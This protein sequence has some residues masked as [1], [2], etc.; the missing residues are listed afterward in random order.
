MQ[1][2][3]STHH[4]ERS[5][6]PSN[7]FDKSLFNNGSFLTPDVRQKVIAIGGGKG[8]VGKSL[9]SANLSI[10]LSLM[11]YKVV[12]VD[13]D[14]GGANLHTCLG[15]PI[16]EH[17]LSDFFLQKTQN[18]SDL[19]VDTNFKN[20]KLISGAQDHIHMANLKS[21]N[22]NKLIKAVQEIDADYVLL[23]LGAGTTFNTLDFFIK[24]D[25][26]VLVVLPEPTSIE[27]TYRF[28]KSIFFR[29]LNM[30]QE[31]LEIKPLINKA[32]NSKMNESLTPKALVQ[33]VIE[34]NPEMGLKLKREI[35]QIKL[36]F[37]LNQ[38]RSQRDIEIGYS[39]QRITKRYF[40]IDIE[41][42]GY[43]EYDSSVWQSVKSCKPVLMEFPNSRL[44]NNF[45]NIVNKIIN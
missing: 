13:L 9:V 11:G 28:I 30:V 32:M 36:K 33:K 43:L 6:N 37:V 41:F 18:L 45:E 14:L 25:E 10:C 7:E 35:E 39:V 5:K 26:G 20:L 12:C 23:D 31:F 40:G 34:L 4:D 27:N 16:P 8:G 15:S 2:S 17:T 3:E 24:A 42:T 22:K 29:R 21:L 44:V 38:V 1:Y 19:A